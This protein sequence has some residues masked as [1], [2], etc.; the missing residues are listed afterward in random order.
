MNSADF[1]IKYDPHRMRNSGGDGDGAVALDAVDLVECKGD[2]LPPNLVE[3]AIAP[4][5]VNISEIEIAD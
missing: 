5:Q 3:A 4:I 1:Y 2:V